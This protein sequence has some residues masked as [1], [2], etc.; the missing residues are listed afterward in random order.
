MK[1]IKRMEIIELDQQDLRVKFSAVLGK[2]DMLI[3]IG[4]SLWI[5]AL[6]GLG[7]ELFHIIFK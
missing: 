5:P 1:I 4:M 7:A 2:L 6:V 3:K